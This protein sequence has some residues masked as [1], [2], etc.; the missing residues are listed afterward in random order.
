MNSRSGRSCGPARGAANRPG[1]GR[2]ASCAAF[3]AWIFAEVANVCQISLHWDV[4]L[5]DLVKSFPTSLWMQKSA[6]LQP[7]SLR[8]FRGVATSC[9]CT[10]APQLAAHHEIVVHK[11]APC[12]SVS[13]DKYISVHLF[14]YSECMFHFGKYGKGAN[15]AYS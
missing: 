11:L 7:R 10:A 6:S 2:A 15:I 5:I 1:M 3:S 9:N 13:F 8:N 4:N 12:R 14:F